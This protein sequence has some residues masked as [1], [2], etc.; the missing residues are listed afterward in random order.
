MLCELPPPFCSLHTSVGV[1]AHKTSNDHITIILQIGILEHR[2]KNH[3]K[4]NI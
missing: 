2:H 3:R 4:L 1:G